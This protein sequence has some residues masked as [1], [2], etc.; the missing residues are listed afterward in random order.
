HARASSAL[1][2]K[3]EHHAALIAVGVQKHGTHIRVPPLA[4]PP[5]AVAPGG[6]NL[7][8]V[9]PHVAQNVR[10]HGTGQGGRD[11]QDR[12]TVQWSCHA[13]QSPLFTLIPLIA[14]VASCVATSCLKSAASISRGRYQ[15]VIQLSM[16]SMPLAATDALP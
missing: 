8:D 11:V 7:D 5:Y 6:F 13:L 16:P 2:L 9:C 15:T 14:C 1:R 4:Q 10:G 12:D 3:V